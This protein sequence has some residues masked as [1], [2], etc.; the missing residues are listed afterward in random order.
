[1]GTLHRFAILAVAF[2]AVPAATAQARDIVVDDD[3]VQ[4]PGAAF[5]AVQPAVDAA[6]RGDVVRV[7]R[8]TYAGQVVVPA[9]LTNVKLV[10]APAGAAVLTAPPGG[11][12]VAEFPLPGAQP[13]A[14]LVSYGDGIY[15]NGFV[16]RGP[17]GPGVSDCHAVFASG[18]AV[19]EGGTTIDGVRIEDTVFGCPGEEFGIGVHAGDAGFFYTS[20]LSRPLRVVVD[21]STIRGVTRGVEVEQRGAV[22][23]QRSL[24]EGPLGEEPGTPDETNGIHTSQTCCHGDGR[25]IKVQ[26]NRFTGWGVAVRVG[27]LTENDVV[28]TGNRTED[29]TR[30]LLLTSGF[31]RAERNTIRGGLRG[32]GVG[33]AFQSEVVADVRENVVRDVGE[34][35]IRHFGTPGCTVA[36]CKSLMRDNS[37]LGSG[38]F[39]CYD[40]TGGARWARNTGVTALPSTICRPPAGTAARRR[41][42]AGP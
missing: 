41:L 8:G 42:G 19:P 35:G 13:R 11:L 38:E 1:M 2:L 5:T 18:I 26:A 37:A 29:A 21:R 23:V 6:V 36:A 40:P 30:G 34:I 22:T 39:D 9:E 3:R 33:P 31:V 14:I 20:D 7:C 25:P 4:C 10:S 32:I 24:L 12:E 16:V 15:V 17:L 28:I 27:S